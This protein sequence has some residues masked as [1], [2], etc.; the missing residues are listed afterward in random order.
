MKLRRWLPFLLMAAIVGGAFLLGP[1]HGGHRSTVERARDIAAGVR[2]PTCGG[3]SAL[4]SQAPISQAIRAEIERRLAAG[5][6]DGQ[7]RAYLVTRYGRSILLKPPTSGITGVVWILPLLALAG[8]SI[9]IA[10]ALRRWQAR[11]RSARLSEDDR[12]LVEAARLPKAPRARRRASRDGPAGL[13]EERAQVLTSLA[14]LDRE[15]AEGDLDEA[16]YV[17]L[18]DDATAR[19]ARLLREIDRV[20]AAPSRRQ[21]APRRRAVPVL[22]VGAALAVGAGLL[23]VSGAGPRH[24]GQTAT[25]SVAVS[26][27]DPLG[28]ARRL[29]QQGKAA[30]ALGVYNQVLAR[31]PRQPEALAYRGLLL[32]MGGQAD[33]G[34]TSIERA[35]MAD[36]TYP[37]AHF[38]RGLLLAQQGDK[39]TAN[40]ELRASLAYDPPPALASAIRDALTQLSKQ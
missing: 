39:A 40:A 10:R 9:G 8:A 29:A 33:L 31:N 5:Q 37:D 12:A 28:Q 1:H 26:S 22:A 13:E 2:C 17:A 4:E 19:A 25:G 27:S 6:S 14:R 15:R 36:P 35:I 20:S 32:A 11:A 23:V 3:E 38:M 7:I 18:R 16:T 24:A 21:V 30:E 34:M